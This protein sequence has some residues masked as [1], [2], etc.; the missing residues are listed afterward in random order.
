MTE[1]KEDV[2][3]AFLRLDKT[4]E[5]LQRVKSFKLPDAKETPLQQATILAGKLVRAR[6]SGALHHA[7]ILRRW[8]R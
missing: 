7:A 5:L 4:R 1:D 2:R 8:R 3:I 6:R